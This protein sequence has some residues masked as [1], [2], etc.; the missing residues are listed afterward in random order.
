MKKKTLIGAFCFGL[1]APLALKAQY[2]T[3]S[4]EVK[5]QVKVMMEA[6]NAHSDAAWEKA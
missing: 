4:P 2:P 3:E 5:A 1:L 6:A